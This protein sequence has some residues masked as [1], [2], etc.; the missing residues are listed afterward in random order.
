M[1]QEEGEEGGVGKQ[2]HGCKADSIAFK[3]VA[4]K[5]REQDAGPG[6]DL[7]ILRHVL[8]IIAKDALEVIPNVSERVRVVD[9]HVNEE[10][11]RQD[12]ACPNAWSFSDYF[13]WRTL[14]QRVVP[15]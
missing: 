14:R 15:T 2:H 10:K 13:Q 7:R 12:P 5:P 8:R 11:A 1:A 4:S 9:E 6:S 3:V